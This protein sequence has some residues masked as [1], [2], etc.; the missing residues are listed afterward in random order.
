MND[1]LPAEGSAKAG[2]EPDL[3][4]EVKFAAPV[5]RYH[6]LEQWIRLHPAGFS[7]AY[8]PRR[9]NNVYF[10][11]HDLEA[12]RE[13]LSGVSRRDKL[14][15][16][17]YGERWQAD[18]S[19]LEVKHRRNQLGWKTLYRVGG[20]DL[21]RESWPQLRRN[22]RGQ[23]PLDGQYWLDSHPLQVLINRYDRQ[24]FEHP[25]R[26]VRVTLD[27]RQVVY[28]QRLRARPNLRRQANLPPSL[29]LEIKFAQKDRILGNQ[30]MQGIPIRV[31]R[32]SKY[33]IGVQS[34]LGS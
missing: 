24:Y 4:Y 16:R 31:S 3:R 34:I 6:E 22:I 17:W 20:F 1:N 10:D 7:S 9:V 21:E 14:R 15:L 12:Y 32:N 30:M 28:D 2:A 29:V 33:T 13:N 8:P 26:K 18:K 25:E 5:T 19:V 11:T 23:L 27:W